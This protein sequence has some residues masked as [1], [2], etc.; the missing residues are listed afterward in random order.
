[1]SRK[2]I[3]TDDAIVHVLN[4][5]A[6]KLPIFRQRSDL[7]RMTYT[8]FFL[9]NENVP[10]NWFREAEKI[11]VLNKLM[12]PKEWGK[13]TPLVSVLAFTIMPNHF[14]LILKSVVEEG[15]QQ[16]MHKFTMSYSKFINSKYAESGSLFQGKFKSVIVDTDEFLR[17]L[18]CYV[19]V[20]NPFELF[21]GGLPAA[22]NNFDTAW[23]EAVDYPFSSLADYAGARNSPIVDK[24]ILGEIFPSPDSF[25]NDSKDF[26]LGQKSD[27]IDQEIHDF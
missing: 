10:E 12:W 11:R 5:G 24:N 25:I 13:R 20:K 4:R 26:M 7:W 15:I 3:I 6:K 1:M 19:M 9:N 18:A 8:L 17:Y 22:A 14:H 21:P 23:K 27:I 16:F 2:E